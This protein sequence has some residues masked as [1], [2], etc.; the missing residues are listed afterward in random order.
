[1]TGMSN[2]TKMATNVYITSAASFAMFCLLINS[3]SM[4]SISSDSSNA[5]NSSTNSALSSNIIANAF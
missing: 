2:D 4:L 1:M 5:I 3:K